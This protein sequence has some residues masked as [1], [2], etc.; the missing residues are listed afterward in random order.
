CSSLGRGFVTSISAHRP[1]ATLLPTDAA[2]CA[3]RT[4]VTRED[5]P[6]LTPAP[7]L[8]VRAWLLC[9][10]P[11]SL[12]RSVPIGCEPWAPSCRLTM[13]ILNPA[14]FPYYEVRNGPMID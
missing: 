9:S 14:L 12:G 1:P 10:R 5:R 6:Y 11:V 8:S 13:G 7:T 3:S 2:G 4:T